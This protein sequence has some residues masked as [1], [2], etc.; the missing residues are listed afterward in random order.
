MLKLIGNPASR[1]GR[2]KWGTS[3]TGAKAL[4]LCGGFTRR[5]KRRSSTSPPAFTIFSSYGHDT[6][7]CGENSL[8]G[9]RYC[10][11][12]RGPSTTPLL[13][14]REAAAPLRMTELIWDDRVRSG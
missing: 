5:L 3:D 13:R 12:A 10:N 2:G 4:T 14:V 1:K 6:H 9:R 7:S 11:D 8:L